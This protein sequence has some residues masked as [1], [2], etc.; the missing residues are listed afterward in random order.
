MRKGR[1]EVI[2]IGD[3]FDKY[4]KTLKAPQG[5]VIKVF[6]EVVFELLTI[7]IN[8]ERIKYSPSTK[9]LSLATGGPLKSEIQ[10]HKKEILTHM[11][12]RLG[13]KSAPKDIL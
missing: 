10:L 3:L 11:K 8:K 2:K 7:E 6:C 5:S 4:R 9:I 13:E 1:G 12:G